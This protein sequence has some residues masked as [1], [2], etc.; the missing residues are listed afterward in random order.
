M[1][2]EDLAVRLVLV[3]AKLATLTGV[4][5]NTESATSI[6]E[7]DARLSIVEVHVDQLLVEKAQNHVDAIIAAPMDQSPVAV[8]AVVALSASADVPE[9]AAIVEDV[10]Q[11]QIES[12]AVDHPEVAEV[13]AA[14][15]S[16]VVTAEPE[17]VV[18][19]SAITATIIAAVSEAPAPSVEAVD[20][21]VDAVTDI[22]IEATGADI[23][24]EV[25]QQVIDAVSALADPALD[26]IEARLAAAEAKVDSLLGK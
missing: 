10:V 3:E 25:Q 19:S 6:E 2:L 8:E 23:T 20:A 17:V 16:A 26:A 7:L 4:S 24:P 14:A 15:I 22:I 13:V 21:T 1:R 18:D 9:A 5:V 12:P 11:A